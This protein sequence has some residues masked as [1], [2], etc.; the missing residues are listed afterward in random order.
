M[1]MSFVT[2]V[3]SMDTTAVSITVYEGLDYH[4]CLQVKNEIEDKVTKYIQ[5]ASGGSYQD[6]NVE[7]RRSRCRPDR[8][9]KQRF[10]LAEQSVSELEKQRPDAHFMVDSPF[11]LLTTSELPYVGTTNSSS[12]DGKSGLLSH[13]PDTNAE[14]DSRRLRQSLGDAIQNGNVHASS[15]FDQVD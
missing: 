1:K 3:M 9:E 8:D 7:A 11:T 13:H 5:S 12:S 10:F 2:L 4:R 15:L 6:G 14:T